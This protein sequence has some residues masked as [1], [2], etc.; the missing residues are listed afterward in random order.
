MTRR[1]I[2]CLVSMNT[3]LQDG[4]DIARKHK[5]SKLKALVMGIQA[6]IN[7]TN[8]PADPIKALKADVNEVEAYQERSAYI[9]SLKWIVSHSDFSLTCLN[10]EEKVDIEQLIEGE[11]FHLSVLNQ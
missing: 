11:V 5:D 3:F 2:T 1:D 6:K 10:S 7:G 4:I 8:F 9:S